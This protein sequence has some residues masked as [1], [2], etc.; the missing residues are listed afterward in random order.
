MT[1]SVKTNTNE[2]R[3]S[4]TT[5]AVFLLLVALSAFSTNVINRMDPRKLDTYPYYLWVYA[6]V[7]IL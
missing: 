5:Q 3:Y 6:L 7:S 2:S 4:F 1:K